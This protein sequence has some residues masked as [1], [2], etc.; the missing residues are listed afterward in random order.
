MK[1]TTPQ[2]LKNFLESTFL[3]VLG[4]SLVIGV[5]VAL[6]FHNTVVNGL[7]IGWFSTIGA[8]VSMMVTRLVTKRN[9]IGNLIGL[10]TAVNSAVVDYYLGNEAAILTYPISFLGAGV[11]Y[12]YWKRRPNRIPRKIDNIFFYNIGIALVLAVGLNY[13]GFTDFLSEPIGDKMSRFLV[14]SAITGITY[15]GILN[16]PRMYADTWASWQI[17]NVLKLYQ[18]ILF[19]NVAYILKYCFYLFNAALAWFVWH[20]IRRNGETE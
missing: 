20:W 1:A 12:L 17:Y 19:G 5:S 16:T 15:S 11:S 8:G 7:P 13:I 9:N 4:V 14:T 2:R 3:D 18:N 6:G 10:L